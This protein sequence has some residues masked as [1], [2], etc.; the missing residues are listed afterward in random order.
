MSA[1]DFDI[2]ATAIYDAVAGNDLLDVGDVQSAGD[3]TSPIDADRI[4]LNLRRV[5]ATGTPDMLIAWHAEDA[6]YRGGRRPLI[7]S[8]AYMAVALTLVEEGTPLLLSKMA[9]AFRVRLTPEARQLLGVD[10]VKPKANAH[11]DQRAWYA[12]GARAVHTIIEPFD[13]WPAPRQV[14]SLAEREAALAARTPE[15]QAKKAPRARQFTNAW[16]EMTLQALP[17]EYRDAWTGALTADQTAVKAPSQ[18]M[19]WRRD[20]E[21]DGSPEVP[22]QWEVV[23]E[24]GD[25]QLIEAPRPVLEIDATPYPKDKSKKDKTFKGGD[26]SYELSFAANIMMMVTEPGKRD[27]HPQLVM[28]ASLH[29][30]GRSVAEH[31]LA[32]VESIQERGY[33][34]KQL[35]VDLGY[36]AGI[37][38]V[39]F[40]LP[41]AKMGVQL[42]SDYHRGQVGVSKAIPGGALLVEGLPVCPA[43]PLDLRTA[44]KDANE[45]TITPV[46]WRAKKDRLKKFALRPKE[47]VNPDDGSQPWMC[48]ARGLSPT[49][50]CVIVEMSK[51]AKVDPKRPKVHQ[52]MLPGHLDKVCR[53]H[54]VRIAAEDLAMFQPIG[55][56]SEAWSRKFGHGRQSIES[57]NEH[58]KSSHFLHESRRRRIHGLAAQSFIFTLILT[59][60][61]LRRINKFLAERAAGIVTPEVEPARK[62]D[63]EDRTR[64]RRFSNPPKVI[65]GQT[66]KEKRQAEAKGRKGKQ[67]TPAVETS[68]GLLNEETA[69]DD[70]SDT[71]T[72]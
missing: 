58:L 49:V 8:R 61:N 44:T 66:T 3:N 11:R 47:A 4:S 67:A 18:L 62:R 51:K 70:S 6:T 37:A 57:L 38:P 56:G 40:H 65:R 54:S 24:N 17:Q 10:K 39:N 71:A 69:F 32:A 50:K 35:T 48:P 59:A 19:P 55:H 53:Q 42:I 20:H 72:G 30:F 7:S 9:T 29:K 13:A 52:K 5:D 21:I 36:S 34:P 28:A 14:M 63:V 26:L 46:E 68:N 22:N 64:Y 15:M 25:V 23:D 27:V 60:A 41:L 31:T 2:V 16:L 33:H 43:T 45:R 12:R 1:D